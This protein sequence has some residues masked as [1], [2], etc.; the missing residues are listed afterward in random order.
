MKIRNGALIGMSF[1][2][3]LAAAVCTEHKVPVGPAGPVPGADPTGTTQAPAPQAD[4]GI[5]DCD[6]PSFS[7]AYSEYASWS[8]FAV[9]EM[10]QKVAAEK[11]KC[12]PIERKYGVDLELK[13]MGYSP[14]IGAY[15]GGTADAVTITHL[16]MLT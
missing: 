2:V 14:S 3:A 9:A 8:T 15:G 1:A 10:E 11:G 7:L 12:G 4:T 16:D 6:L 5:A 13:F